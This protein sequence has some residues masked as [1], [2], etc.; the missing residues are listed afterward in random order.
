MVDDLISAE[1]PDPSKDKRLFELVKRHN[2][3]PHNHLDVPYSRCNKNGKC[4]YNFPHPECPETTV[5]EYGR[6]YLRRRREYD[7]WIVSYI[8]ALTRLMEAHVHVDICFTSNAFLYLYK[9]LFKGV[10]Q[11]KYT[12]GED[13]P[14]DEFRDYLAARYLSSAEAAYRILAFHIT[15]KTPA[16]Q[17]LSLHLPGQQLGR[18]GGKNGST[19]MMSM[20]LVYLARPRETAFVNLKFIDFFQH[21]SATAINDNNRGKSFDAIVNSSIPGEERQYGLKRIKKPR[22][23]RL[24]LIPLRAGELFYFR[25]LLVHKAGYSF[26]DFRT[27][28]GIVHPT[29]QKAATEL[30]LFQDENEVERAMEEGVESLLRP[31]QLRFIFANLIADLPVGPI[32]AWNRFEGELTKD[33]AQSGPGTASNRALREIG[34]YLRNRG[35]TL[36]QMGLPVPNSLPKA[37]QS[38]LDIFTSRLGELRRCAAQREL[39]FNTEQE[40][41]F[42]FLKAAC[43]SPDATPPMFL[44]GMAGRGKSYVMECLT[45]WLRGRE[46]I[47]LITGSTAQSVRDYERGSTA[48][49]RFGIPVTEDNSNIKCR[50]SPRSDEADLIR[51]SKLIIWDELPMANRAA[52]EAVDA[53]LRDLKGSELPFGGIKFLGVGDFRQVAPVVKGQNRTGVLE[54]S[55]KSSHLWSHFKVLKLSAPV[56][57]ATDP[58]FS[59]WVDSI[60]EDSNGLGTIDVTDQAQSTSPGDAKAWLFPP[61]VVSKPEICAQRSY[62]TTLNKDVDDFNSRVLDSLENPSGMF[63]FPTVLV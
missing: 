4:C 20:L 50:I 6:V 22:V 48:H 63:S 19:S 29:F 56:R 10:D 35:V 33:F 11:S 28:D 17:S 3:H 57:N 49:F 5:D 15:R 53:L 24:H 2:R 1:M 42:R 30:G 7:A 37:V 52:V 55:I 40:G 41:I 14:A 12:I 32:R 44:D 62:L 38:E 46:N 16:V 59:A 34:Q 9:Y 43:E 13:R 23:C 39:S 25:A 54:S 36:E 61:D 27:I 31:S 26:E 18:M 58:E 45:W 8:P 51:A 47:V 21:F 60:G